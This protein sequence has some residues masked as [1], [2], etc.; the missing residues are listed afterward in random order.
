VVVVIVSILSVLGVQMIA[1]GSVERNLQQHGRILQSSIEYSCDQATLQNIP[2]GVKFY[3]NGY[4]F[5]QF[6][7]QQWLDVLTNEPLYPRDLTDGSI[8]ELNIEGE[9]IVLSDE[10]EEIPQL[11][12]D[13][14]GQI[15]DFELIISDATDK[16]HYL[17]ETLDF[18]NIEGQW[19]DDKKS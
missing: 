2:Y 16:H 3:L 6:V 8:L 15:N 1:S 17:L 12:C 11:L 5:T 19:L 7:N 13:S 18:W 9:S 14:N 10:P 4:V